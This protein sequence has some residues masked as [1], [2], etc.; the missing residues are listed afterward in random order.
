MEKLFYDLTIGVASGVLTSALALASKQQWP[1]IQSWFD[2]EIRRQAKMIQGQWTTTEAFLA[3]KTQGTY[4]LTIKP[5]GRRIT[6]SLRGLE[7]P[8]PDAD[9]DIEGTFKDLILT[10]TWRKK[11]LHALESG[12]TTAKLVREGTLEG[13]GLYI[14]PRD[15]KVH[16]STFRAEHGTRRAVGGA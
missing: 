9:F 12:A 15:G 13:H 11:G 7:G 14:E 8:D 4:S 6:G 10:F 3:S 16:T 5:K 1:L 2:P